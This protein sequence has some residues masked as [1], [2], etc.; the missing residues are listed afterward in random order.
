MGKG[1]G[2][3]LLKAKVFSGARV[4]SCWVAFGLCVGLLS[5]FGLFLA[6]V[7]VGK[8]LPCHQNSR[9]GRHPGRFV[10]HRRMLYRGS[11]LL[12]TASYKQTCQ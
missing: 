11:F 3:D 10:W 6:L 7:G 4:F 8:Y 1:K 12:C 5:F 9:G 2:L